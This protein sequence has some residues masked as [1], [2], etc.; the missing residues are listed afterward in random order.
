MSRS[1]AS[2]RVGLMWSALLASGCGPDRFS[3]P[4]RPGS[5]STAEPESAKTIF[6]VGT[7]SRDERE[8]IYAYATQREANSRQ[9]IYRP[10]GTAPGGQPGAIRKALADGASALI[11]VPGDAPDLGAALAEA[12]SKQVPVILLGREVPAPAG[13]GP[14][15][16]V[17]QQ[18][19]EESARR[20]VATTI[21]DAKKAGRPGDGVAKILFDLRDKDD[22]APRVEALKLAA[23]AA[24]LRKV[25]VVPIQGP[26][27]EASAAAVFDLLGKDKELTIILVDGEEVMQG[28]SKARIK[29]AANPP[30][31]VGG[32]IGNTS[33]SSPV[34]FGRESCFVQV[35][36]EDLG[37]LATRTALARLRGEPAEPR[38]V[39]STKF[40]RGT[41]SLS[42]AEE[43]K[44]LDQSNYYPVGP[45]AK[46][47]A[48]PAAGTPRPQ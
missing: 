6:F 13:S 28:V 35:Y 18:P 41:G 19:Y 11:V 37:R 1:V 48:E 27:G 3:V 33:G 38:V 40:N 16:V 43:A 46:K 14:F 36:P 23:E 26:P 15:T 44:L 2:F 25:E 30:I 17:V 4:P 42:T 39:Q 21:E 7:G 34:I 24:G 47:A 29:L 10:A 32:F 22:S 20:I 8:Q 5:A 12:E 9:A 45:A 31:F